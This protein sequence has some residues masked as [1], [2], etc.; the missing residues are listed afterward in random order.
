MLP[1]AAATVA[2]SATDRLRDIPTDFWIKVGIGVVGL[3]VLVI[4][5][6]KLAGMNKV[7]LGVIVAV[8]LSLVGFTWIY[9]RN[10]PAWATP[11]VQWLAQFL[12]TKGKLESKHP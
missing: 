9:E 5:L 6:R 11:V 1:L 3:I 7:V 2:K 12:P 4:V 8:G 10:E